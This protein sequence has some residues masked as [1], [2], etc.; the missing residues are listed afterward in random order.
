MVTT[1]G[2]DSRVALLQLR[3]LRFGLLLDGEVGVGVFPEGGDHGLMF[4]NRQTQTT[5]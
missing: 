3:V 5:S 4:K 2:C 1:L